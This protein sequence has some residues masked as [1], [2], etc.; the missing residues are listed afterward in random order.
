MLRRLRSP[1]LIA[2]V[3]IAASEAGVRVASPRLPDPLV[4]NSREVQEK[5]EQLQYLATQS[6]PI[7]FVGSSAMN[8]AADPALTRRLV[9]PGLVAYNASLNGAD[10]RSVEFWLEH[11][12]VPRVHPAVVVIGTTS[13]ELNDNGITQRDFLRR[14][15]TSDA[16]RRLTGSAGFLGRAE[17]WLEERSFLVRYRGELRRP[18]SLLG[19]G[20]RETGNQV[21]PGGT[22]T[23]LAEFQSRP[24]AISP[25]FRRR[26]ERESYHRFAVGGVQIAALGRTVDALRRAGIRVV[27]VQLPVTED[28]VSLHP[29]GIRDVGR[30]E[31]VL[32]RFMRSRKAT[33]ADATSRI[34][35]RRFFVDPLHLNAAGRRRFTEFIA[36]TVGREVVR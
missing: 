28:I 9:G 11:V 21:G 6:R 16:A 15:R 29:D 3:L 33:L 26:A 18:T 30:Y 19:L 34:R 12:V 31:R 25:E 36:P 35:D 22:L 32:D 17:D 1:L 5:A 14:L 2:L 23:T 20:T 27:I 7:V 24:Y 10:L 4:W 13:L 8:A